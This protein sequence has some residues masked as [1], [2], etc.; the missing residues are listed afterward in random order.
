MAGSVFFMVVF[1]P[2]DDK[3]NPDGK[4]GGRD[5]GNREVPWI[6]VT[7]DEE[8]PDVELCDDSEG[9]AFEFV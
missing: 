1:T 6:V 3:G 9:L 8:D 7:R 2:G 5:V 4:I